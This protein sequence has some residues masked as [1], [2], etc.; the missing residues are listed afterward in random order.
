MCVFPRATLL[1]ALLDVKFEKG[2][3]EVKSDSVHVPASLLKE[4]LRELEDPIVPAELYSAC[5][6]AA[7]EEPI[8]PQKVCN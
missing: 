7:K 5:V 8:S 4:W 3:Y 2:N 6:E 1:W